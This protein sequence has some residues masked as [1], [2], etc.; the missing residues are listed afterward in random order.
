MKVLP[1]VFGLLT[2]FVL[3]SFTD[4]VDNQPVSN[5]QPPGTAAPNHILFKCGRDYMGCQNMCYYYY[6]LGRSNYLTDSGKGSKVP[7][8]NRAT[9]G[10]RHKPFHAAGL[11]NHSTT[12]WTD[13][14]WTA[15]EY[16]PA[17]ALEGGDGAALVGHDT[18][19][20]IQGGLFNVMWGRL[21]DNN[22]GPL[23]AQG[24]VEIYDW[25]PTDS[26]AC[27]CKPN[28]PEHTYHNPFGGLCNCNS[29]PKGDY[30]YRQ[31]EDSGGARDGKAKYEKWRPDSNWGTS[32][33]NYFGFG[34]MKKQE[35]EFARAKIP[36]E[37]DLQSLPCKTCTTEIAI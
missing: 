28:W 5:A 34:S 29:D 1:L 25:N 4:G 6:C 16:P 36:Q 14:H 37:D 21:R 20:R 19:Y 3:F 13:A 11:Q 31:T 10:W 18:D 22:V 30:I 32:P 9:S 15:D 23:P 12:R 27:N 17:Q 8:H 24:W 33:W 2:I 26:P 7:S 35:L